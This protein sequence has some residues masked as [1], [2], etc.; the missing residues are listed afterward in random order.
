MGQASKSRSHYGCINCKNR[1]VKCGEEKLYARIVF[2]CGWPVDTRAPGR[3]EG[4]RKMIEVNTKNQF[5]LM[6]CS[7]KLHR[8]LRPTNS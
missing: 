6:I 7:R 4:R 1:K 5:I 2:G 3:V 8:D